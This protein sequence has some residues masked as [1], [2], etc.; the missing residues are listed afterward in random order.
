TT[1]H[2]VDGQGIAISS[3]NG[4]AAVWYASPAVEYHLSSS[5]GFIAGAEFA[6]AG[7][8]NAASVTPQASV[9]MVF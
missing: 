5:V 4:P 2:G 1:V 6:F 9:V 3:T 8:N 7:R